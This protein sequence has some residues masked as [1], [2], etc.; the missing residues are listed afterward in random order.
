M[1]AIVGAPAAALIVFDATGALASVLALVAC[2]R[3]LVSRRK[4]ALAKMDAQAR[5][6][7]LEMESATA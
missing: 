4:V 7:G 2:R 1:F 5:T 6:D 3:W